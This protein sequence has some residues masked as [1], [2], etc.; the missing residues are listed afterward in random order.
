MNKFY[1]LFSMVPGVLC[2]SACT[3]T[4]TATPDEIIIIQQFDV[5]DWDP[6]ADK[7]AEHCARF[8]KAARLIS[9]TGRI[10]RFACE[11]GS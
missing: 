6:A 11:H 10:R 1:A 2:L 3:E 9:K 7:A 8:G 4:F 5:W